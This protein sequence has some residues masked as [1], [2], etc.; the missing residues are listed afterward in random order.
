MC[1]LWCLWPQLLDLPTL[2]PSLEVLEIP[3][4]MGQESQTDSPVDMWCVA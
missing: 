3:L 1:W 4:S 2:A